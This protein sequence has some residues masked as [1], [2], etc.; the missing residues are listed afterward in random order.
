[1]DFDLRLPIGGGREDLLLLG[2]NG[3]V[4]L[5]ERRGHA[6]Q[7]LDA[8]RQRRH[9]E[10]DDFLHVAA[11]HAGLNGRAQGHDLIG[12]NALVRLAAE[13]LAHRLLDSRHTRH[14][15]DQDDLGDLISADA[16]V[17]QRLA[18]RLDGA[19]HQIF[20]QLLQLGPRHGQVQVLRPGGVGGDEGQI[21][22][23]L[24]RRR[25]L[26]LGLLGRLAQPL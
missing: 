18:A 14:A 6:A 15:A 8:Q 10:Q 26:D 24:H 3:R 16:G 25:Q 11:Q 20:G 7:R 23:A 5:D 4:A 17:L 9:V 22:L 1:V 12:V 19:L 2:R 21:Q 13:E